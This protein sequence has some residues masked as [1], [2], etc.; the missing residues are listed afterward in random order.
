M[1]DLILVISQLALKMR[2][3]VPPSK[4]S[5]FAAFPPLPYPYS[6]VK[7]TGKTTFGHVSKDGLWAWVAR[8]SMLEV[9]STRTQE[10]CSSWCFGA[11]L[12]N[13]A[14]TISAIT[15]L[16]SPLISY[17]CLLI[18]VDTKADGGLLCMFNV[19]TSKVAKVIQLPYKITS[20]EVVSGEG[21]IA[22]ETPL[23][24]VL[25]CM[26]GLVAVGTECGHILLMDLCLDEE[27]YSDE[28]SPSKVTFVT[29]ATSNIPGR[30][31]VCLPRGQHLCLCLNDG[32]V[33]YEIFEYKSSSTVLS[34]F[35]ADDVYVSTM[36]YMRS[37]TVL[38][39]GF[40]FGGIQLWNMQNLCVQQTL[41]VRS[42]QVP[43]AVVQFA[44]QEPENDPK[45]FCYLWGITGFHQGENFRPSSLSVATLYS[46]MYSKKTWITGFGYLYQG[47]VTCSKRFEYTLS[48][49]PFSSVSYS[50]PICSRLITCHVVPP[51]DGLYRLDAEDNLQTEELNISEDLSTCV[52]AWEVWPSVGDSPSSCYLVFFDIN[53]W[54]QAQMPSM[55]RCESGELCSY[56][57]VFSLQAITSKMNSES[58]LDIYVVPHSL[59]KFKCLTVAEEFFYPSSLSFKTWCI[60]VGGSV[61]ANYLGT[62]RQLLSEMN[63]TGPNCLIDPKDL[64]N[65]CLVSGLLNH[66]QET[67]PARHVSTVLQRE[68][69]LTLAL[70]QNMCHFLHSCITKWSTGEFMQMGCSAKF[71]LEW[72]WK[73]VT[74]IKASVDKL[75]QPLFN[76]SIRGVDK[77]TMH[78][79]LSYENQLK[80]LINVMISFQ[81][82]SGPKTEQGKRELSLRIEAVQS[83]ALYLHVLIWLYDSHLLPEHCEGEEFGED[84]VA[85]PVSR[86]E[87]TYSCRRLEL[88]KLHS[89]IGATD[90]LLV[91]GLLAEMGPDVANLWETKGGTGIYPPPSLYAAVST[92]LLDGV[93]RQHKHQLLFYVILDMT[94]FLCDRQAHLLDKLTKFPCAFNI[95]PSIAKLAQAFWYLDHQDFETA[96]SAL[97]DPILL[98]DDIAPWCHTRILKSFLY[99]GH[100]QKAL[101]Y[102]S[103]RKPPQCSAEDIKM[104]LSILLANSFIHEAF[105]Y[106]RQHQSETNVEDLLNHLFQSCHQIHSLDAV[107]QFPLNPME[108]AALVEFLRSC[109]EPQAQE[110]LVMYHL[111]HCAP[112]D[113]S[114][115]NEKLISE[116]AHSS[117][118]QERGKIRNALVTGFLNT[119][120]EEQKIL[121]QEIR[122]MAVTQS[123]QSNYVETKLEP[124]STTITASSLKMKSYSDLLSIIMEKISTV[125]AASACL[126]PTPFKSKSVPSAP[127]TP[128][129][130]T[131]VA[132]QSSRKSGTPS[133]VIFATPV[134]KRSISRTSEIQDFSSPTKKPRYM[135]NMSFRGVDSERRRSTSHLLPDVLSLLQTP[136]IIRK[137][138]QFRSPVSKDGLSN[139]TPQ[140]I[141]KMRRSLSPP[142]KDH[143]STKSSSSSKDEESSEDEAMICDSKTEEKKALPIIDDGQSKHLRFQDS[144]PPHSLSESKWLHRKNWSSVSSRGNQQND[145][146]GLST[147]LERSFKA[148][149][150]RPLRD[151]DISGSST[152]S[153]VFV[154]ARDSFSPSV[155]SSSGVRNTLNTDI[156]HAVI[157]KSITE[158]RHTSLEKS[159]CLGNIAPKPPP[160]S[161]PTVLSDVFRDKN[162]LEMTPSTSDEK[163]FTEEVEVD[164]ACDEDRDMSTEYEGFKESHPCPG[165]I[166]PPSSPFREEPGENFSLHLSDTDQ[167]SNSEFKKPENKAS[168]LKQSDRTFFRTCSNESF[169]KE[170]INS[171]TVVT[172]TEMHRVSVSEKECHFTSEQSS[173]KSAFLASSEDDRGS[174]ISTVLTAKKGEK[175]FEVRNADK[176][177]VVAE[178]ET[179][180]NATCAVSDKDVDSDVENDECYEVA[181]TIHTAEPSQDYMA[182]VERITDVSE[183]RTTSED[184]DLVKESGSADT[185][186]TYTVKEPELLDY[187]DPVFEKSTTIIEVEVETVHTEIDND[188]EGGVEL[189]YIYPAMDH[190]DKELQETSSLIVEVD[191]EDREYTSL[192]PELTIIDSDALKHSSED[193]REDSG[194]LVEDENEE[195]GI[196]VHHESLELDE[197]HEVKQRDAST[198]EVSTSV[199]VAADPSRKSEGADLPSPI[200]SHAKGRLSP[201][202][203]DFESSPYR[204]TRSRSRSKSKSGSPKAVIRPMCEVLTP[205]Q[206]SEQSFMEPPSEEDKSSSQGSEEKMLTATPKSKGTYI[207]SLKAKHR[208]RPEKSI[209]EDKSSSR[210]PQSEAT[211]PVVM[212]KGRRKP[213]SGKKVDPSQYSFADPDTDPSVSQ[214]PSVLETLKSP[215]ETPVPSFVFSPPLTRARLRQKK[216][217]D[218][219]N[220]SYMSAASEFSFSMGARTLQDDPLLA[221]SSSLIPENSIVSASAERPSHSLKRSATKKKKSLASTYS[222]LPIS[223]SV[224]NFVPPLESEDGSPLQGSRRSSTAR[225]SMIL[226]KAKVKRKSVKLW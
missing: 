43:A 62:Q 31:E 15:E 11:V 111:L 97:L 96:M 98:S 63:Q 105:H 101:H 82:L 104:H 10:R 47:F 80:R 208:N 78:S 83:V 17:P 149:P 202:D 139:I 34:S 90:I 185:E 167:E 188:G 183:E 216:F 147:P 218:T 76:C 66:M 109:S 146:F 199:G 169:T 7:T 151:L 102:I 186:L 184:M 154:A 160:P 51:T 127:S 203:P 224:I 44:F 176:S 136:P 20:L 191:S 222:E 215:P 72:A 113:A 5:D 24:S 57:G 6:S 142:G 141:L 173:V 28:I 211:T 164:D 213:R 52:M 163:L 116:L 212:H 152:S 123:N 3:E 145:S 170:S 187:S 175:W 140:S 89:S 220:S 1:H 65:C 23:S 100:Q 95:S 166:T 195:S 50:K 196:N 69:L 19:K 49:D 158:S 162:N 221:D 133:N 46:L 117:K 121:A 201:S 209:L 35:P 205:K 26:F 200:R 120:P 73:R 161:L 29:K 25:R 42:N 4:I 64:Y 217:N 189:E 148:S 39:V 130:G 194:A 129:V 126:P 84:E 204:G 37:L 156:V 180:G 112:L 119:L 81:T 106:Q 21:G 91:D 226:R 153:D 172:H 32:N 27:T 9:F 178:T 181:S 38:A 214:D 54:Y 177:H 108:N 85:Y 59:T 88:Q 143:L 33:T 182:P 207:M 103:V 131:P 41:P 190:G 110:L 206:L 134:T 60:S 138:S 56:L 55:L 58:L 128:F 94:D 53:Q 14:F 192:V 18:G 92:Y 107:L 168:P 223:R 165:E 16:C 8:D 30:R 86:L 79:M 48:N 99:Q 12:K 174:D 2:R 22:I 87:R 135:E 159:L 157:E 93:S 68:A 171:K 77:S 198:P 125:S 70:E 124:L 155:S 74:Q 13:A 210:L 36:K 225:H 61:H 137:P 115:L 67:L 219:M 40:N 193:F 132:S 197:M 179:V 122:R 45:N 150:R 144:S 114:N 118:N 75:C 71:L